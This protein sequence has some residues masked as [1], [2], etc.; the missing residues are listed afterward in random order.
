MRNS[1]A[2]TSIVHA[3]CRSGSSF[4]SILV[5]IFKMIFPRSG[6][7][8]TVIIIFYDTQEFRQINFPVALAIISTT[9]IS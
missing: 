1:L 5:V 2:S 7:S 9:I 4:I 8:F 6:R 3:S